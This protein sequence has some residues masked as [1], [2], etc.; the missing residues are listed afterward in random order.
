MRFGL[1]KGVLGILVAAPALAWGAPAQAQQ[2]PQ[3]ALVNVAG[4]L[5]RW[6]NNFHYGVVYDTPDGLIV[7]DTINADASRWLKGQLAERF[8]GKQV[9]Y[10]ILAYPVNAHDRYM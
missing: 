4:D 1:W 9:K 3:R 10:V 6:Q 7:G 8:P 5:Y 2:E